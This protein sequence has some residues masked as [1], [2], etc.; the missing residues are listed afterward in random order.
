MDI[1]E[2]QLY[3]LEV[4]KEFAALCDQNNLRYC[5]Y[6]GTLLGAVR[7]GGYIPWDDDVDVLMPWED[8]NKFLKTYSKQLP[9][10]YFVQNYKTDPCFPL[11]FTQLRVNNTTSMPVKNAPLDIHWGICIDIFPLVGIA[12]SGMKRKLQNKMIPLIYSFLSVD[13]IKA[14]NVPCAGMQKIINK[15]PR[16][17]RHAFVNAEYAVLFSGSEKQ[18]KCYDLFDTK[19]KD[20]GDYSDWTDTEDMLFEGIPFKVPKKYDKLLT[21]L[22]GD[23]MTPPPVDQRGGHEI[24]LGDQILDF[25]KDYSIYRQ[26]LL[27]R[28]NGQK[29]S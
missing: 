23:Y 16:K 21:L 28:E 29:R 25:N 17:I 1:R 9:D 15:I 10:K 6:G 18:K 13:I 4:L 3:K 12:E 8:Y 2:L 26:E 7:H 22:Y 5:L 14:V 27:D 24:Q 11:M 20:I 19:I